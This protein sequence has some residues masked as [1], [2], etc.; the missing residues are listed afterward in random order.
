MVHVLVSRDGPEP[1][2]TKGVFEVSLDQDV[3]N[4]ACARITHHAAT[5]M[6][7]VPVRPDGL[8]TY[9][10]RNVQRDSLVVSA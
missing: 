1:Y 6:D 7:H 10:I 8:V 4:F 9:V 3:W 5:S 2:A